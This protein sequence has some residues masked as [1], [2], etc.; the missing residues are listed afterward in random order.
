MTAEADRY[1]RR[2]AAQLRRGGVANVVIC[3]GSRSTPLT[4]AFT[5]DSTDIKPWLHLD[6]RSA[7]YF[8]LGLA[9]QLDEQVALVCTSGTAA[10]NFLPAVVE[11]WLSRVPLVVLTADRPPELRDVGASQTIDQVDL[12]RGHVLWSVDMPVADG[13]E[14]VDRY[15][16]GVAARATEL[17]MG[18]PAGPVHLNF[19]FRE[20]LLDESTA[21]ATA[22]LSDEAESPSMAGTAVTT[23]VLD[24]SSETATRLA[25]AFAGHRGLIVCGPESQGLPAEEL[26]ALAGALGW[27]LLADPLS[28]LRVGTHDLTSVVETYDALLSDEAF[29]VSVEPE[30][31]L[32]FGAAL[33]SKPAN[34][35][36]ATLTDAAHYIVDA[37]GW[38]DPDALAS[39]VVRADPSA[40]ARVL[41]SQ[42]GAPADD[43]WLARWVAANEAARGALHD[44]LAAL[45]EPF[46]G[47]AAVE[48]LDAL[49][50]GATL[51]VGNS[52]AVRDVDSFV[53]SLGREIRI[54][55]TRGAAGID[56]VV[57]TAVGAA[58]AGRGPVALLIGDLS[59]FHDLNGLWAL[60]RH[61]LDLTVL[62]V[63]NDG[64]GI[65]HFLPQSDLVPD[66][67]EE[68]YGTAHGLD[69]RGVVEMY[70][71]T[72]APLEGHSGWGDALAGALNESGLS[73][74]E[75]RTERVRNVELHRQ[76]RT[77]VQ[78][79]VR[80]ALKSAGVMP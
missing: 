56:G 70:G 1:V 30:L 2:F 63:N 16:V 44:A 78:D 23:G 72:F 80:D 20:P 71:G 28:G 12:Y 29:A 59:F 8:A 46:E 22:A 26:V 55:G 4:L 47:R 49:P 14:A 10:A 61:G 38:R 54:V 43:A 17:A 13:S 32:R 25:A 15:A 3:P 40:F 41:L 36:I 66:R 75:L 65:F 19:P 51:V 67:F 21:Y 39:E 53:S 6:E 24:I 57:S 74:L 79:A 27:P 58:A 9:R 34:Q 42:A 11:A 62:L 45:D 35:W 18:S 77:E 60:R 76:I 52:M 69:F 68:W 7:G 33:T 5:D 37:G 48:L 50:D 73:V 64:G 31:I